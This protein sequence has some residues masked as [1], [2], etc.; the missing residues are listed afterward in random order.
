MGIV[1]LFRDRGVDYRESGSHHHVRHGWVGTDCPDC[2]PGWSH[3]RL[4][5]N[6]RRRMFYC[7]YCGPRKTAHTLVRL[8]NIDYDEAHQ[9]AREELRAYD[10][11]NPQLLGL[12]RRGT[13]QLP[14]DVGTLTQVHRSYLKS[15]GLD[16]YEIET[17]WGVAGI[18]ICSRRALS[19]RL[20]IPI[21]TKEGEVASWTTRAVS[22]ARLPRYVSASASQEKENSKLLLYGE[23]L[24]PGH[25]IVVC[26]GPV[27]AWAIGPGA[28]ALTGLSY[29]MSQVW[30]VAQYPVRVVCFDN[31]DEAQIKAR[32]L[33]E[34][35]SMFPGE[36]YQ[37]RLQCGKDPGECAQS[38]SG[39]AELFALRRRFLDGDVA[40]S[41]VAYT[42]R[43]RRERV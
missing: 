15:R 26:E 2:S 3:Y 37:V 17:V 33:A 35:L 16:P 20:F 32:R 7:W 10:D 31:T 42:A 14:P 39:R 40:A 1:E 30:R 36:T 29:S 19:W 18:G 8:L 13:L 28:V 34:S 41:G 9:L 25:S 21:K 4:G 11:R 24:V 5:Y 12:D 22:E 38:L 43:Q 6:L 23:N 27:D